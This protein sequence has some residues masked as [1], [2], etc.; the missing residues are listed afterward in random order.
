MDEIDREIGLVLLKRLWQRGL[1]SE[2][3][4]HSASRSRVF[5]RMYFSRVLEAEL[6]PFQ[7]RK[8]ARQ[9]DDD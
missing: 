5:D 3:L 4:Y 7:E 6:E 2:S 1:I 8:E 9:S